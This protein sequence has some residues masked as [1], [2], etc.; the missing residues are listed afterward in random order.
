MLHDT[1]GLGAMRVAEAV[2]EVLTKLPPPGDG[3]DRVTVSI[4]IAFFPRHGAVLDEVVNVA[5][6]AM[7]Q[8]KAQGRD[9]IV[10]AP[11]PVPQPVSPLVRNTE[12]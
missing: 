2:Q 9:R 7:Y 12:A 3:V 1:D 5:D 10:L 8:A 6:V 11:D 4:G